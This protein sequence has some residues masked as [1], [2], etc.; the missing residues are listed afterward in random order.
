MLGP[1]DG[2]SKMTIK[3]YRIKNNLTVRQF[4]KMLH[5]S[6]TLIVFYENKKQPVSSI[7]KHLLTLVSNGEI[8]E[9]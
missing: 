4:A 1:Q 8:T 3:E 5:C 9:F 2:E 6:H 7:M